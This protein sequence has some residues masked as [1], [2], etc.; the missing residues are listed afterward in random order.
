MWI[1]FLRRRFL[2]NIMVITELN[3]IVIRF[4]QMLSWYSVYWFLQ[5]FTN[6]FQGWSV[7]VYSKADYDDAWLASVNYIIIIIL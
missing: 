6:I 7:Q 2:S 4:L 3:F 5:T 1:S